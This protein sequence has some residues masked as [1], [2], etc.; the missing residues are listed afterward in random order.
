[1]EFSKFKHALSDEAKKLKFDP[2][3]VVNQECL[4]TTFQ[5]CYFISASF[6]EAK[7][8]MRLNLKCI[9]SYFLYTSN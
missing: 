4:I 2:E 5:E 1:M 3:I 6:Q 7:E 9:I 8:Q